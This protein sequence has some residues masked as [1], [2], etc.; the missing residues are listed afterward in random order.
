VARWH[1][2]FLEALAPIQQ[3]TFHRETV[4][5]VDATPDGEQD[6]ILRVGRLLRGEHVE[7]TW[8]EIPLTVGSLDR[9]PAGADEFGFAAVFSVTVRLGGQGIELEVRRRV[10][11]GS[12]CG[13]RGRAS[14]RRSPGRDGPGVVDQGD[15]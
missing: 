10:L 5:D 6:A 4:A 3:R 15:W 7:A 14:R 1:L 9:V 13:A 2:P 8:S 12:A 11:L